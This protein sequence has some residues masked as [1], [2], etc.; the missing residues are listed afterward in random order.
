MLVHGKVAMTS[1]SAVTVPGRSVGGVR[2]SGA[3]WMRSRKLISWGRRKA[4]AF[5]PSGT[6]CTAGCLVDRWAYGGHA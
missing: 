5:V 1:P 6:L 4:A 2:G 3:D